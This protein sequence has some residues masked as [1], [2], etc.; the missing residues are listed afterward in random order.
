MT[1]PDPRCRI[2]SRR[3]ARTRY[4]LAAASGLAVLLAAGCSSAGGSRG[5]GLGH[6]HD[7]RGA[8]RRG[9]SD[10]PGPEGRPV[11][12][13]GPQERRSSRATRTR[14]PE[15]AALQSAQADIAA[16]DYGNIFYQQSQSHDLRILADGYDATLGVLEVLTL[17]GS[18][19]NSPADLANLKVGLPDDNVLAG[20]QGSGDP[21]SLDAAAATQVLSNYLGNAADSVRWEPM[22]QAQEVSDLL[23]AQASGHPGQRALHLPGR[24]PGRRRRGPGRVQRVDR[25]PAAARLRGDERL[26]PGQPARPSLTSR[27]PWPRPSPRRR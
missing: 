19:I 20:L 15:L 17:P 25:E 24:E 26:G 3:A 7:R 10:L 22:S 9:R 8:G 12:G 27:P 11:R 13:R 21:V 18:T 23:A 16:S 14:L 4:V 1:R 5:Y 6:H 2:R